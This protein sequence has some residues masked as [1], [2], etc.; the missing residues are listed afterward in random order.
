MHGM[1][2]KF[3]IHIDCRRLGLAQQ[4]GPSQHEN[5]KEEDERRQDEASTDVKLA[6]HFELLET[7]AARTAADHQLSEGH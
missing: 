2:L 6:P 3:A 4:H 5:G 1:A 7:Q